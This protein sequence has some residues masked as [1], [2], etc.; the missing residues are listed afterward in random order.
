MSTTTGTADALLEVES[1]E[2]TLAGTGSK[3]LDG[4]DA[5]VHRGEILGMVGESGAGKSMTA[6]AM[7][8]MLPSGVRLTGGRVRFDGTDLAAAGPRTLRQLRG[9]QIGMVFQDP[10]SS[11]NP[12]MTV[13]AQITEALRLHG[14]SRKAATARAT[15]LLDLVGIRSPQTA[16]TSY[17]HEFS[18]GMRQRVMIAIAVANNPRL[19]I[20]DEPTTGLDVTI[21]AEVLA[22]LTRL[23]DE[24]GTAVLLIT[25][26]IGVVQ[27][28]CDR[29]MVLYGGRAAETGTV[30]QVLGTAEHPYT[31]ELI[32]SV[33][34]LGAARQRRLA[35]IPGTPPAPGELTGGCLFAPRCPVAQERCHHAVPPLTARGDGH[36]ASCWVTADGPADLTAHAAHRG[37]P[38]D[39]GSAVQPQDADPGAP[40]VSLQDVRIRYGA[41]TRRNRRG[42]PGAVDGVTLTARRGRVLGLIGESG[43]GKTSIA[44]A[45]VGLVPP[46]S[47][48]VT[49][50]GQLWS[51]ATGEELAR[52][53]RTVQLVFQDSLAS[54]NPRW[55]V[56]Q[57]VSEPL[58]GN[59]P[60]FG[61]TLEQLLSAVG[62]D[63]AMLDRYPDEL[64]GGQR[65]RV[66]IARALAIGPQ[67]IVA[68][69]PVSALDVSVQAQVINLLADLRDQ[70]GVGLV[71]VAH[72][73]AV[74]QH[75][76]DEVAVMYGGRIVEQ[77]PADQVLSTP[78]HPYTTRLIASV[79]GSGNV[80]RRIAR[81]RE[82]TATAGQAAAVTDTGADA[83]A[84]S[85]PAVSGG[86]RFRDRCPIGPLVNP[87]RTI[88]AEVDP[89]LGT[90]EQHRA[91]C[92]F[93]A[94]AS[95][96]PDLSSARSN[97]R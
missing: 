31:F 2:V 76:C 81:L 59:E 58:R 51:A 65:Q 38:D 45:I 53:R 74:A 48:S 64:S 54:M 97:R 39:T 56:R 63:P 82:P 87:Q 24:L 42:A 57:I 61:L 3:L 27:E 47:G 79:P 46:A 22:L 13:G 93:A 89:Q 43:S 71:F 1:L 52:M 88:C 34:R 7:M 35:T 12:L 68:D 26:D 84:A 50:H 92:H 60:G 25:H 78:L 18:G 44:R 72:D 70:F 9:G 80:V 32:R 86:C 33:P 21:Q 90:G 75:I 66:G 83:G 14:T 30:A 85:A 16:V 20:A 6:L 67:L 55:R 28:I 96:E 73:L 91:A 15:E 29:I 23:R 36:F 8:Q 40:I 10:L 49:V 41:A 19:L 95:T 77:G 69:E 4:V 17:P 11:L 5:R 94:P 37:E 62:L